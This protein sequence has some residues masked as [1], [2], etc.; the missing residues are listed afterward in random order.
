M[1]DA[2]GGVV[3]PG[4][5]DDGVGG[6]HVP[7]SKVA[8]DGL[9]HP[10]LLYHEAPAQGDILADQLL[11]GVT[12]HPLDGVAVAAHIVSSPVEQGH[13]P[14]ELGLPGR[15]DVHGSSLLGM[16]R[17]N[18]RGGLSVPFVVSF[19]LPEAVLQG[20]AA[21]ENQ[22]LRG[23]VHAVQAEVAQAHELEGGRGM[24]QLLG[25]LVV[26]RRSQKAPLHLAA[27]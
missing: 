27:G 13:Q 23:G 25:L 3:W 7:T 26:L 24:A 2:V 16:M 6:L 20:D 15:S 1:D 12:V 10:A 14:G 18:K 22:V 17:M 21:V 5:V 19:S 8:E 11:A 9:G 4:A